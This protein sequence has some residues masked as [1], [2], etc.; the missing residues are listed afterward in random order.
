MAVASRGPLGHA[1]LP[2]GARVAERPCQPPS[3]LGTT[4][5]C[6]T[7]TAARCPT[8]PPRPT[9]TPPTSCSPKKWGSQTTEPAPPRP[10]WAALAR[11]W[12]TPARPAA[13]SRS[14]SPTRRSTRSAGSRLRRLTSTT[15]S[16]PAP[17]V[18]N[19]PTTCLTTPNWLPSPRSPLRHGDRDRHADRDD[20]RRLPL[21]KIKSP[22]RSARRNRPRHPRHRPAESEAVPNLRRSTP[23]PP[24]GPGL[25]H[26]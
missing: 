19:L 9:P 24:T 22:P 23:P 20:A 4:A 14:A 5:A 17:A 26:L 10:S 11:R 25:P 8:S 18:S 12:P 16:A 6:P 1:G 7:A 2:V 21:R 3:P 15:S 13:A